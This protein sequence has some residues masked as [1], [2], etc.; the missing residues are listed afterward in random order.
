MAVPQKNDSPSS[1]SNQLLK[2]PLLE[3]DKLLPIY[4][5]NLAGFILCRSCVGN[6]KCYESMSTTVMSLPEDNTA[7]LCSIIWL[8]NSFHL[9]FSYAP[10]FDHARHICPVSHECSLTQFYILL[11]RLREDVQPS[12]K[13]SVWHTHSPHC[14]SIL[15]MFRSLKLISQTEALIIW[16]IS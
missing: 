8:L 12:Q 5:K 10:S 6:H 14:T 13:S 7:T 3:V 15:V 9:L 11:K 1:R 16:P 2:V 4:A